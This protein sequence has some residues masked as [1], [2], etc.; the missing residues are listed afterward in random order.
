MIVMLGHLSGNKLATGV[1]H[2]IYG[3]VFF[4][5]VIMLMFMIGARWAEHPDA[6]ECVIA[7]GSEA[8]VAPSAGRIWV[9]AVLVAV[10]GALPP[11]WLALI[12][13][14]EANRQAPL[15]SLVLPAVPGWQAAPALTVNWRPAF[16]NPAAELRAEYT[17]GERR[18]GVFIGYYRQQTYQQKLVSSENVLVRSNDH[19]WA[20]VA[21]GRRVVTIDDRSVGVRTAEL[22]AAND[23][24]LAVWQWYWIGGRLTTSDYLA[25]AYQAWSRLLGQG[26]DSAVVVLY[27]AKGQDGIGESTLQDFA[28]AAGPAVETALEHLR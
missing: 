23:H 13:R 8:G 2:L 27:A 20:N 12:E 1:D 9:A 19:E 4:G 3:W 22:R 24:R 28:G 7:G 26:D 11:L 17:Q 15:P 14:G 25:K 10:V 16:A 21:S 5:I 6:S 18:V